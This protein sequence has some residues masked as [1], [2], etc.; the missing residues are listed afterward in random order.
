MELEYEVSCSAERLIRSAF[1]P[2]TSMF[3]CSALNV[4][5]LSLNIINSVLI[6]R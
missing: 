3:S 1:Q 5:R 2:L 6:L 4:K